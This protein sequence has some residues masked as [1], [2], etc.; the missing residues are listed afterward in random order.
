V[1]DLPWLNRVDDEWVKTLGAYKHIVTL[2]NHYL[3]YG[4]GVMIAAALARNG[5]RA[6]ISPIGLKEIPACGSNAD[7]LAYHGLDPAGIARTVL[8]RAVVRK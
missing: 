3:E 8:K 4:Q 1:I 6:E 5:V 2:D 7:V